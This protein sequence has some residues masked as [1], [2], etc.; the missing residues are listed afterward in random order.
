[1]CISCISS[2]TTHSLVM[3]LHPPFTVHVQMSL[4]LSQLPTWAVKRPCLGGWGR[5]TSSDTMLAYKR[6]CMLGNKRDKEETGAQ[7]KKK[8]KKANRPLGGRCLVGGFGV[9]TAS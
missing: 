8:K 1:V 6:G 7:K 9:F 4:R 3:E 2:K 5:S